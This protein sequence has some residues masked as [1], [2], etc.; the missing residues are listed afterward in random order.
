MEKQV[1]RIGIGVAVQ[2]SV[3]E[4]GK[5][6]KKLKKRLTGCRF[7]DAVIILEELAK[8][9]EDLATKQGE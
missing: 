8:A 2:R 6:V 1:K 5:K 3:S 7:I 9:K 4:M